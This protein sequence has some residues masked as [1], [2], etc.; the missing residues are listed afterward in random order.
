MSKTGAVSV[1]VTIDGQSARL[2]VAHLAAILTS[3][4]LTLHEWEKKAIAKAQE[5]ISPYSLTT[6]PHNL[7]SPEAAIA[8]ARD[9]VA[10][11]NERRETVKRLEALF[12][13]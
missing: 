3:H 8:D 1:T 10:D 2:T 7:G 13:S 9:T 5:A 6:V 11:V 12:K 4:S